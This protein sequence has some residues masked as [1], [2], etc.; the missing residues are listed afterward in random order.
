[1][2][3][4]YVHTDYWRRL[5]ERQD[6]SAVGQSSLTAGLNAWIYR[7]IGRNLRRFATRHG[8]A[9]GGGR[10]MLEVG[11]GTGYWIPLWTSLGWQVDGCDLV[12]AAVENLRA[13]HPE[14][15]FWRCDISADTDPLVT[16]GGLADGPYD[17][18]T[19]TS[20]LLHVTRPKAFR[21]ALANVAAAVAPDGHLLL[22]EPVLL[23]KKRQPPYDPQKTSRMRVLRSYVEPL[24]EHGLELVT[25]EAATVLAANPLEAT[26][27]RRLA[28]YQ[29]WWAQVARARHHPWQAR[30]L[31]P[32]MYAGD[33]V[34]M[35]TQ[36]APTAKILLF[37]RTRPAAPAERAT[38]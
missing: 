34:L 12:D 21:R 20:I 15:R 18:V 13:D 17:L 4:N 5:H 31:G 10:R 36:E 6:L 14:G 8:L 33:R 19:A 11:V 23:T 22:V 35:R 24:R 25:V 28:L 1:M 16:S 26:S 32:A 3:K 2:P 9:S 30:L 29:R 7:S 37:R 38:G 27:R